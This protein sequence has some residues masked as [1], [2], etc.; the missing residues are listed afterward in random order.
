LAAVM[1]GT[2]TAPVLA[3]PT[4]VVAAIIIVARVVATII[5]V[6]RVVATI[7][8]VARVVAAITTAARVV[9]AIICITRVVAAIIVITRVVAAIIVASFVII[10]PL[11]WLGCDDDNEGHQQGQQEPNGLTGEDTHVCVGRG[12]G[13]QNSWRLL[14][15]L[16]LPTFH[17]VYICP[18]CG[19]KGISCGLPGRDKYTHSLYTHRRHV[20]S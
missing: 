11:F 5:V 16:I 14:A 3:G 4:W 8:V 2:N 15:D 17:P 9:A 20:F 6:A 18:S 10:S 7:I 1:V 12:D 13:G 19:G